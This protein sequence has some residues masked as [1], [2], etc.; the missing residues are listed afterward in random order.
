MALLSSQLYQDHVSEDSIFLRYLMRLNEKSKE[1]ICR[2]LENFLSHADEIPS[3]SNDKPADSLVLSFASSMW[4]A[5]SRT[6]SADEPPKELDDELDV[7][8]PQQT[9]ASLSISLLLILVCRPKFDGKENT[10]KEML[11]LF[12]NAQG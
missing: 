1:L 6:V 12:Q 8:Y 9:L 3:F 4:S 7:H 2:L 10:H 11:S 5:L